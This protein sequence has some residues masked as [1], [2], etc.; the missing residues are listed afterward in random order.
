M[1]RGRARRARHARARSRR[2]TV[3]AVVGDQHYTAEADADGH[4][5]LPLPPGPARVVGLR[6]GHN[7]FV[8]QETLAAQQELAVTYL[9]ERERYNR[10]EIVVIARAAA[11][12]GL[13]HHAAR[14]TRSSRCRARSAIRSA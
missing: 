4:F 13:A 11:R 6:A 2:A 8:Q 14:A 7:A 1:L 12:G 10:Y 5:R 3:T 9:V